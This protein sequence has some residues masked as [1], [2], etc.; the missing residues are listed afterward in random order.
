MNVNTAMTTDVVEKPIEWKL[1]ITYGILA[2][3]AIVPTW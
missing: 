1:P 2:L 3:V